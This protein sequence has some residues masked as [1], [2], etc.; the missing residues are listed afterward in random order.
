M[1][2]PDM[3]DI[4]EQDL[5]RHDKLNEI[6]STVGAA[7]LGLQ[8]HCC[9]CHDHKYD[10]ISQADFFRLRGCFEAAVPVMKRDKPVNQL[11]AQAAA[12]TPWLYH[13]GE[14]RSPGPQVSPRPPRIACSADSHVAFDA[15]HPREALVEWLFANE[16]PLTARVIAN[17]IWQHHFGRSLTENPSDFGIIASGPSHL[18]LL[19]WLATELRRNDWSIKHLH[20]SILLSAT[21]QQASSPG[22]SDHDEENWNRATI[23][24]PGNKLYSRFP[25]KRLE[26]E[27]IRDA[28]LAISGQLNSEYGGPSVRPPLPRELTTTLLTG[29]WSASEH[30]ADHTRRSIYVFARRNLRYPIF[31]VFDRPDAGATCARRDRSTTAIQALQMLNSGLV[32]DAARHLRDRLVSE[33]VQSKQTATVDLQPQSQV[34]ERLFLHVLSRHPT[35]VEL[36]RLSEVL[37]SGESFGDDLLAAC[38]GLFNAS[39]FVY[40]D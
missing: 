26:G 31:E 25:R 16:N 30:P 17:R 20:R 14:L 39:E 33:E 15:D 12:V 29:Q 6:T 3:P 7:I 23:A 1:A 27:A 35:E 2:G 32:F 19:D 36:E 5:R 10:P 24:D 40:V 4:N 38:V 21:Y 28:L 13:R 37:S 22:S 8:M 18:Q 34:I 11:S 9:Q